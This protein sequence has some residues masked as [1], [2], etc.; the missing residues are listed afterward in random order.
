MR[1]EE[2]MLY[3][4]Y[5]IWSIYMSY[6]FMKKFSDMNEMDTFC[7]LHRELHNS[8]EQSLLS[9]SK[10]YRYRYLSYYNLKF[11]I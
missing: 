7:Y 4:Y 8:V 2:T 5:S 6:L 11:H 10:K 3:V 9:Y 1:Y